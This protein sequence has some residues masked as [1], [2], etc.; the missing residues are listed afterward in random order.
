MCIFLMNFFF[1]FFT[2]STNLSM[3][4]IIWPGMLYMLFVVIWVS[5]FNAELQCLATYR[6]HQADEL[7]IPEWVNWDKGYTMKDSTLSKVLSKNSKNYASNGRTLLFLW[8]SLI[9]PSKIMAIDMYSQLHDIHLCNAVTHDPS[10]LG[11]AR[12]RLDPHQT[13][14]PIHCTLSGPSWHMYRLSSV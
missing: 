6:L 4:M 8:P 1:F 9:L 2:C 10:E 7:T 5:I 12:D 3:C 13:L 11:Q 14:L